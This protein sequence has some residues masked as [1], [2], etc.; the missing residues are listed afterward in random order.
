MIISGVAMIIQGMFPF[1]MYDLP[2]QRK[3]DIDEFVR[4]SSILQPKIERHSGPENKKVLAKKTR[5]II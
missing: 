2:I 1:F 5:E 3:M 4:N